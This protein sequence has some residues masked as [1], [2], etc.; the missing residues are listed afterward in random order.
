MMYSIA[1]PNAHQQ[2]AR[3]EGGVVL[4]IGK[5]GWQSSRR[6]DITLGLGRCEGL[7]L[8]PLCGNLLGVVS[9]GHAAMWVHVCCCGLGW[10]QQLPL[11]I[12][13][14]AAHVWQREVALPAVGERFLITQG[15]KYCASPGS[16]AWDLL[17]C[18]DSCCCEGTSRTWGSWLCSL[19]KRSVM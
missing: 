17:E 12:Y 19:W 9:A 15:N 3:G 14:P 5:W 8:H 1:V 4:I 6:G 18:L 7:V 2:T 16:Y 11:V 13:G 10:L